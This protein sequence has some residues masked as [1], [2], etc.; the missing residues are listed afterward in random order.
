V[1]TPAG[2]SAGREAGNA[3]GA[4]CSAPAARAATPPEVP[5][6]VAL[7][8]LCIEKRIGLSNLVRHQS[9]AL[10]GRRRCLASFP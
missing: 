8:G 1:S 6:R 2:V 10:A 3:G 9:G 5:E 7:R 4:L